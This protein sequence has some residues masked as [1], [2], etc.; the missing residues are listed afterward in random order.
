MHPRTD[1]YRYTGSIR[2]IAITMRTPISS[3]IIRVVSR[4]TVSAQLQHG[5]LAREGHPDLNGF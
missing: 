1:Y 5:L 4:H 2:Q 3:Q